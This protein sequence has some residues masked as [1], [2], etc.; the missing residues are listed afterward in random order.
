MIGTGRYLGTDDLVD[1]ATLSPALPYAYENS[2]YAF[3]DELTDLG[4][5]RLRSDM[6]SRTL[7]TTPYNAYYY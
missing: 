4:D 1:G 6:Q 3:T 5:L 7:S 2:M